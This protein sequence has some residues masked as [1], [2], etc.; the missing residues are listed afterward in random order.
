MGLNCNGQSHKTPD[1]LCRSPAAFLKVGDR[2]QIQDKISALLEFVHR[3]R[4]EVHLPLCA[5]EMHRHRVSC[6]FCL[7]HGAL[8][9]PDKSHVPGSGCLS[10]SF[11]MWGGGAEPQPWRIK[12]KADCW[13]GWSVTVMGQPWWCCLLFVCKHLPEL[14]LLCGLSREKTGE[15]N[16]NRANGF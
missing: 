8:H 16:I 15:E 1:H 2:V 13:G 4:V 5:Q 3:N 12:H 6:T 14:G 10:M 7:C 9:G 11:R